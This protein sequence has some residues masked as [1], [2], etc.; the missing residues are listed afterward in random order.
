MVIWWPVWM[1]TFNMV[2]ISIMTS[3]YWLNG[4]QYWS[5]QQRISQPN[6]SLTC[7]VRNLVKPCRCRHQPKPLYKPSSNS[8]WL[9]GK[10][11]SYSSMIISSYPMW[12]IIIYCWIWYHIILL[13]FFIAM[14]NQGWENSTW[15]AGAARRRSAGAEELWWADLD[16]AGGQNVFS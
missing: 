12:Y 7:C 4:D 9:G 11:P 3:I 14:S 2:K 5:V 13:G 1:V 6:H 16:L 15:P 10:S 8:T